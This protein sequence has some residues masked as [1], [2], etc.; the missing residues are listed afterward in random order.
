MYQNG[1]A[2]A[3]PGQ[4]PLY[5]LSAGVMLLLTSL[6]KFLLANAPNVT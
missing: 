6:I 3:K 5:H 4:R 1:A 2:A